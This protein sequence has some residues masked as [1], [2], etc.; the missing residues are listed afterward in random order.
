MV[1]DLHV[2]LSKKCVFRQTKRL[3]EKIVVRLWE[4]RYSYI[5]M[6]RS[7]TIHQGDKSLAMLVHDVTIAMLILYVYRLSKG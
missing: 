1:H 5:P 2:V 6:F 7:H 4:R 3:V